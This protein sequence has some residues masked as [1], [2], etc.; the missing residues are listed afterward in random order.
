MFLL[1]HVNFMESLKLHK[2]CH[3]SLRVC[4]PFL[5]SNFLS[6]ELETEL[7]K[8]GMHVHQSWFFFIMASLFFLH[9]GTESC[10][11]GDIGIG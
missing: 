10:T 3:V 2:T 7:P 5:Y 1:C 9:T 6:M 4:L 8:K 11:D